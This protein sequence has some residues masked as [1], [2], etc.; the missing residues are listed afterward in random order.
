MREEE[1]FFE[2]DSYWGRTFSKMI[3][4]IETI[5]TIKDVRDYNN[6]ISKLTRN[7]KGEKSP[8]FSETMDHPTKFYLI[9][10]LG[11]VHSLLLKKANASYNKVL[12]EGIF[13]LIDKIID[14]KNTEF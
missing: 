3:S 14:L 1:I 4:D 8:M 13:E 2:D 12:K 7:F 11:P 5:S 6:L 9:V 10:K